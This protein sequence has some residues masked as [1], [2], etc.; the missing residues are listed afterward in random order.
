M[1]AKKMTAPGGS[2]K[3]YLHKQIAD[4]EFRRAYEARMVV[5]ELAMAVRRMREEEGLTQAQLAALI[6]VKQPMIARVERGSD[7]RTPR[8]DVLRRVGLALGK[9]LVLEF[10]SSKRPVPLVQNRR[11]AASRRCVSQREEVRRSTAG[12]SRP[13]PGHHLAGIGR[14]SRTDIFEPP[15]D[16]RMQPLAPVGVEVVPAVG[17]QLVQ[18]K[19]AT[20]NVCPECPHRAG[21]LFCFPG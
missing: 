2:F 14:A 4:P 21:H 3:D 1:T 9:Q 17:E 19:A 11:R 8:W 6:G 18:Q 7:Q 12:R 15:V 20:S 13:Q 10:V 16:E 5:A